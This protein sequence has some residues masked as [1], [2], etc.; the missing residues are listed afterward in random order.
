MRVWVPFYVYSLG[1]EASL[2][3]TVRRT[4][5]VCAYSVFK[6][7]SLVE[8]VNLSPLLQMY[9]LNV[10]IEQRGPL[11]SLY[12]CYTYALR[13]LCTSQNFIVITNTY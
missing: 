7:L 12:D 8:I 13:L 11:Q 2:I 1:G 10:I 6:V 4:S 5:F 3:D 9:Y